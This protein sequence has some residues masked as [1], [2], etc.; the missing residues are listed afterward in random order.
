VATR[1]IMPALGM[2]QDTGR[3][4]RWLVAEG[5]L[6]AA[7]QPLVEIETD[8]VTTE[9]ESPAAG[10]LAGVR[11]RPGED[12]PV[13]QVIAFV[14]APGESQPPVDLQ[15][16]P[17]KAGLG[18]PPHV[19]ATAPPSSPGGRPA[20]S[21]K[22]R[23]LAQERGVDLAA[24]SG[25]GPGGEITA[26]DV[27]KVDTSRPAAPRTVAGSAAWARV[28][29]RMT[30]SWTS[31]PHFYLTRELSAHAMVDRRKQWLPQ[32]P[33]VTYTDIIICVV[34]KAL[35]QHP[36][37][38]GRWK[39][40]TV[41]VA[42]QIGIGVAV[43]TDTGLLV[44]VVQRADEL[45]L[46]EIARR[47]FDLV[48]RA[49]SGQ[50]QLDDVVGGTF[51]ISNLGMYGVD[52]VAPILNPPQAAILGVGR[53]A[54]RV[55]AVDGAPTVRPM[56]TLTLSCDHRVVDGARAAQF[57]ETLARGLEILEGLVP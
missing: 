10:F 29:E 6:V 21:P 25:S 24:L 56:M 43:A 52:A 48:T 38:N 31:A 41:V 40:G 2:S 49:Q 12:V 22:A 9:I 30:Q 33:T 36:Q 23:R 18:A 35:R 5:T 16:P 34:A 27:M 53:I 20:A 13:G 11:V 46:S 37:L 39:E 54:D 14:L 4:L 42:D 51:T 3:L 15:E 45:A 17:P 57:L 1:V 32:I 55:V 50:L 19:S 8:K 28:A 7:G 26:A 44:P 47:R